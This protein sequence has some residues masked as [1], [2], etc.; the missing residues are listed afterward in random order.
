MKVQ[1]V[2]PTLG[3]DDGKIV[4]SLVSYGLPEYVPAGEIIDVPVR[5]RRA[6]AALARCRGR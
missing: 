4:P 2:D 1:L 5:G 3:K 6:G